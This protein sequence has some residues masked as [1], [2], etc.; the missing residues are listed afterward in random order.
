MKSVRDNFIIRQATST[1][2]D[3]IAHVLLGKVTHYG[4]HDWFFPYQDEYP[5]DFHDWWWRYCRRLVL[6][7]GL[8]TLV[9]EVPMTS[10]IVG[11]A[12]WSFEPQT[13]L[14]L[15]KYSYQPSGLER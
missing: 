10:E 3:G 15:A 13:N 7:P 11:M 4:F 14:L 1:D 5:E 8:M 2:V 6:R 12:M 9:A